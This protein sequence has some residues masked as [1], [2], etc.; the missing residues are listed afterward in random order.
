MS[1]EL[2]AL[3]IHRSLTRPLLVMGGER[4]PM[5]LLALTNFTLVFVGMNVVTLVLAGVLQV[6][7]SIVFVNM[8]K[9]D[10]MMFTTYSKHIQ[11]RGRLSAR[12]NAWTS[13]RKVQKWN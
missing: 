2:I 9:A 11:M 8:A 12:A 13:T 5:L 10:P 1:D 6:L 4:V 3:P 7:L